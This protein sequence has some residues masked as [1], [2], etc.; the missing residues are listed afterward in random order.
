VREQQARLAGQ[1]H[2]AAAPLEQRH[3]DVPG[4][5]GQLL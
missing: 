5:A 4:Q 3:A 1:H 2:G